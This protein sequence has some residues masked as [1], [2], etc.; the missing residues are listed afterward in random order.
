QSF[1]IDYG[2]RKLSFGQIS[3]SGP[4]VAF[5]AGLPYVVV[6][7]HEQGSAIRLLVDSGTNHLILFDQK[8]RPRFPSFRPRGTKSLS[9]INGS[10][11]LKQVELADAR[12]GDLPLPGRRALVLDTPA[13][14]I[15]NFDGLLGVTTLGV[16]RVEFDFERRVLRW[17]H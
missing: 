4:G 14:G 9:N 7:L 11:T 17:T 16:K 5:E 1:S 13:A 15:R 6:N 12:L 3:T 10:V 2:S 8:V